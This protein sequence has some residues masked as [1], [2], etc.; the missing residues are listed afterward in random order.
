[1][2]MPPGNVLFEDPPSHDVHR[3][4]LSRGF[5][6]KRML[7][8]EPQVRAFCARTLDPLVGSGGFDFVHDLGAEMPMRT[9]GMLLGIPESDQEAIRDRLDAG[10]RLAEGDTPPAPR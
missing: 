10:M 2:E 7:A 6:P 8:I 9:I 5:T 3:G 1:M 4:L